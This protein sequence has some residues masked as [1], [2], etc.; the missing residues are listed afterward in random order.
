MPNTLGPVIVYA[1]LTIPSVMLLEAFLSFLGLGV[2]APLASWGSLAADGVQNIAVFPWQLICPGVTMAVTLFSLNFLGD[3]LRDALDPQMRKALVRD[4]APL[5]SCATCAPGSTRTNASCKAV[6][7][8]SFD[9][10]RGETLGIVGESGSGKSVT[11]LSIM[12]LIPTAAGPHRL[13]ARSCST[14]RTC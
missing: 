9:L 7:G 8:V 13:A 11:N 10:A 3:G 5:L 1:T 6:D 14:V 4:R 12:R 2:Q